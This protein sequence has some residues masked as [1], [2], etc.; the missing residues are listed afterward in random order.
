MLAFLKQSTCFMYQLNNLYPLELFDFYYVAQLYH[1]LDALSLLCT[2][3]FVFLLRPFSLYKKMCCRQISVPSSMKFL[4]CPQEHVFL[5]ISG[6]GD[7][8]TKLTLWNIPVKVLG[9]CLYLPSK[10]QVILDTQYYGSKILLLT[11]SC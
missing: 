3:S 5:N 2:F 9:Q 6:R 8:P 1:K 7:F 10:F 4:G 11:E